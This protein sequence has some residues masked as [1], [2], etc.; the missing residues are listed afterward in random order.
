MLKRKVH[1]YTKRCMTESLCCMPEANTLYINY[2]STKILNTSPP[3]C[4][5]QKG[6]EGG[7]LITRSREI[8]TVIPASRVGTAI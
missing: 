6:L 8:I 5:V 2:I 7:L 4:S 1:V 3:K